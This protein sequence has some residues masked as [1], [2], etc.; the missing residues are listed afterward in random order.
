VPA[1]LRRATRSL[2][3]EVSSSVHVTWGT[4]ATPAISGEPALW[5]G[6]ALIGLAPLSTSSKWVRAVLV[7]ATR[8]S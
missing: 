3:A 6:F 2:D 1:L 4:P 8:I 5:A 7:R